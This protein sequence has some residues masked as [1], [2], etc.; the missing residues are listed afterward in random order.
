MTAMGMI[1][2]SSVLVLCR[3]WHLSEQCWTGARWDF[4]LRWSGLDH[5]TDPCARRHILAI[6]NF[7]SA[8]SAAAGDADPPEE[9]HRLADG[10]AWIN[11]MI[12]QATGIWRGGPGRIRKVISSATP[13][14]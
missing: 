5:I 13:S 2:S 1:V 12:R 7:I 3:F 9:G 4:V 8:T 10:T 11:D 14:A 6:G